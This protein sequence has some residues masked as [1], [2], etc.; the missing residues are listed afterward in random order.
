M[1]RNIYQVD[2]FTNVAFGGNPAGVLPDAKGLSREQMQIIAREMNLSETAFVFPGREGYDFE[3]RFFTPKE[4]V[5]LCG[6]A[7][8]ATFSLLREIGVI[9]QDKEVL[10]QKT[11][12][13]ILEIRMIKGNQVLMR[14]AIPETRS[15]LQALEELNAA[16]MIDAADTGIDGVMETAEIWS[17]GLADILL[18]I[19]S[20]E[21]LKN[22][23]P[24]MD[25]LAKLSDELDVIGVHAFAF[26]EKGA[27]WCRNFAPAC[28][29]TEESATGTSNGALGACLHAKGWQAGGE[30]SFTAHQ[31][32]WM[33][34]P[35]R[36]FVK[37]EGDEHPEV[38]VGGSAVT[39]LSGEM[40]VP[41]IAY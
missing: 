31:G 20:V 24:S 16:M 28:G 12:A 38:W 22:M 37:V 1:K 10:F 19:K 41:E 40:I 32:D 4:E 21:L 6:H 3:V 13:G 7:T 18:P 35:S 5:D 27:L 9:A 2:A 34:S 23:T 29:I 11:K 30:I 36:I 25:K 33:G 39:I 14:Q 26:D 17:T 15:C 8:I